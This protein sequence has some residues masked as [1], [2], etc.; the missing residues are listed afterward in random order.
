[1]CCRL[2][3]KTRLQDFV[4]GWQAFYKAVRIAVAVKTHDH[5]SE[6]NRF[7]TFPAVPKTEQCFGHSR[8]TLGTLL[9]PRT[10]RVVPFPREQDTAAA[11]RGED[12]K[13][14]N[15]LLNS[16]SLQQTHLPKNQVLLV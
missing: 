6:R 7:E 3:A 11:K 13:G 12:Q 16:V 9:L 10:F 15:A 5:C 14:Q 8:A 2:C 1:M 4:P